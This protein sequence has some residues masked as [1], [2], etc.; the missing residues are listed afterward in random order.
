M[1]IY[2]VDY[3]GGAAFQS[4]ILKNHEVGWAAGFFAETFGNAW[5]IVKKLAETGKAPAIRVHALWDDLH[6]YG[7][8]EQLA[9]V[10]QH[11]KRCCN[12]A[13][14]FPQIEFYFS[15]YCE[16]NLKAAEMEK[17]LE[18]CRK[19]IANNKCNNITL[20]NCVWQ[21]ETIRQPDVVNEVHGNHAAPSGNY[22]YSFDGLDCYN[23][24]TQK[25]K[26]T[27]AKAQIFFFWT[28][29]MNLKRKE[30]EKLTVKQRLDRKY[31]PQSCNIQAMIAMKP[32]KGQ[33]NVPKTVTI[34]PMSED[35]GDLKSNKLLVLLKGKYKEVKLIRNNRQQTEIETLKRYDPPTGDFYRY[36]ASKSGYEYVKKNLV[37][38]KADGKILKYEEREILF[39]PAFRDGTYRD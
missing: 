21:G 35:C 5:T 13:T 36:Y 14:Q 16:H 9:K 10:K 26:Q 23:A 8:A 34:K 2:G 27:Y 15:P 24:N 19:I 29:S 7:S 11:C 39:N 12:I 6:R 4:L 37:K 38:I 33:T 3:L 31:R 20:V 22:I 28:I 32:N 30:D 25:K 17:T 18:A 1:S